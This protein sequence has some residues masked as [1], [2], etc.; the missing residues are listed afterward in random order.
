MIALLILVQYIQCGP[1]WLGSQRGTRYDRPRAGKQGRVLSPPIRCTKPQVAHSFQRDREAALLGCEIDQEIYVPAV[2]DAMEV[3]DVGFADFD[4]WRDAF[5]DHPVKCATGQRWTK[6]S[7][8]PKRTCPLPRSHL[9][10]RF[11]KSASSAAA[12]L[13][14]T[15]SPPKSLLMLSATSSLHPAVFLC[16]QQG[17]DDL[18]TG[19]EELFQFAQ[20][21]FLNRRK[22]GRIS[23]SNSS[24]RMTI[25]P[26]EPQ[27]QLTHLHPLCRS[28]K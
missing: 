20:S 10:L 26:S 12:S 24:S 14:A 2:L 7:A 9:R 23:T 25:L 17:I 5:S 6:P 16:G 4:V 19:L 13:L 11:G 28:Q 21:G 3:E 15:A 1:Y 18:P 27:P 8:P 22:G